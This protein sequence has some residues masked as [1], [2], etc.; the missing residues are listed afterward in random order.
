MAAMECAKAA[1]EPEP[2]K[3]PFSRYLLDVQVG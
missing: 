3:V 1:M 2:W